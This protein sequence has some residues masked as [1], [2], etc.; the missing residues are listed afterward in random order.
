M[1][2]LIAPESVRMNRAAR[3]L[4]PDQ[5]GPLTR[6]PHGKGTYSP[7][8]AWGDPTLA[9]CEKGQAVVESMVSTIVKDIDDLHQASVSIAK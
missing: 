8:G 9:T 3:D 7:T 5:P 6:G 2:L 4:N 1:M